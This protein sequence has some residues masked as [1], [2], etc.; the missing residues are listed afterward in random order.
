MNWVPSPNFDRRPESTVIDTIVIHYT[1]MPC[2][3]ESLDRLCDPFVKVSS[4]EL[5]GEDGSILSLVRHKHRAWH[6][7]ESLWQGRSRVNDFSIGIELQNPGHKYFREHGVW[8]PYPGLL[9]EALDRLLTY[10]CSIYPITSIIGHCDVAPLRKIDPG[11]HFDWERLKKRFG[12][13]IMERP[14][15][16]CVVV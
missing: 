11:P 5:I 9:M 4:H 1:N 3:L 13:K 8:Q 6:A 15:T 10:L 14:L 2:V 16:P 7:G 12:M